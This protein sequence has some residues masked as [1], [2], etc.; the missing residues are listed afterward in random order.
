MRSMPYGFDFMPLFFVYGTLM[1]D[2]CRAALWPHA[3]LKVERAEARGALYDL[4]S[5]P[6][7]TAGDDRVAGEIWHIAAEHLAATNAV[8][9]EIEGYAGAEDDLYRRV[10]IHCDTT[11]GSVTASTYLYAHAVEESQRIQ[12]GADGLCRWVN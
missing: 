11:A 7:M 3:A 5:Y 8:L 10:E 2:G 1:R 4:G 9:D 6:G 12:P